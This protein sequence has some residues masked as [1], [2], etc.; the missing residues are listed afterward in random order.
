MIEWAWSLVTGILWSVWRAIIAYAREHPVA[1]VVAILAFLRMFG[2]TVQTGWAGVLF[3]WGRARKVLE[4][5]FHPLIP[6]VQQ[7][8]QTPIRSVT[9]ELPKQRVA[10]GDGL[11]YDVHT[12]I[13]YHIED[14]IQA[15]VSIDDVKQGI[16]TI[17]PLLVHDL[18]REQTRETLS[19][20]EALDHELTERA[21]PALLRWGV[22]VETAGMSTIAP[23]RPTVKLS[24]LSARVGERAKLL[25]EQIGDGLDPILATALTTAVTAPLGHSMARYRRHRLLVGKEFDK[26]RVTVILPRYGKLTVNNVP[27]KTT[28]HQWF[29]T[30]KLD[31]D[32]NYFYTMKME[33]ILHGVKLEETRK[34]PLVA[35]QTVTVDFTRPAPVSTP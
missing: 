14:P 15:L 25:R 16:K 34:I 13:V 19:R 24:Q 8:R 26:A 6:I 11:V 3:S 23:T 1:V 28:D 18:L 35:G 17:V 21:K 4:P 20:R 5:G 31:K 22:A 32:K 33:Y 10:T 7:V 30:P 12:T 2:T 29:E 27:V 9:L